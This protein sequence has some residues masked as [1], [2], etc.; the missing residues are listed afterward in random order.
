VIGLGVS[1]LP[2]TRITSATING[3]LRP[4]APANARSVAFSRPCPSGSLDNRGWP[5]LVLNL[6]KNSSCYEAIRHFFFETSIVLVLTF[7]R[8]GR[9]ADEVWNCCS[10]VSEGEERRETIQFHLFIPW[11]IDMQTP[12]ELV[13][14]E[15][16]EREHHLICMLCVGDETSTLVLRVLAVKE[17]R[18]NHLICRICRGD[19]TP[20]LF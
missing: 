14:D 6:H 18:Q 12:Q 17:M 11:K 16:D 4:T 2:V 1:D 3:Q 13:G 15:G 5:S 19:E 9:L 10:D 8:V 20:P 7:I